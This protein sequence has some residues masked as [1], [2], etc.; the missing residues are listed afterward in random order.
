LPAGVFASQ[1]S[2]DNNVLSRITRDGVRATV[3]R[4][5]SL[6]KRG[7]EWDLSHL[8]EHRYSG[9]RELP[10]GD[11][12]PQAGQDWSADADAA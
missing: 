7:Q 12:W 8:V 5:S 11:L 1:V 4:A 9:K 3:Q 10:P 6:L 2:P